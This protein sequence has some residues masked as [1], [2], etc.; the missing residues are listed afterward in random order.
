VGERM[1]KYEYGFC[2][3][4]IRFWK[5]EKRKRRDAHMSLWQRK[6]IIKDESYEI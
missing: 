2:K 5:A 1:S 4:E 6:I 3:R